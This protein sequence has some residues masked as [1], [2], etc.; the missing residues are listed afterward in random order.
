MVPEKEYQYCNAVINATRK[1][2][3][4]MY[5]FRKEKE[6]IEEMEDQLTYG[7]ELSTKEVVAIINKIFL[8]RLIGALLNDD[9]IGNDKALEIFEFTAEAFNNMKQMI[10]DCVRDEED[11]YDSIG[12]VTANRTQYEFLS[13][14][15]QGYERVVFDLIVCQIDYLLETFADI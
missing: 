9:E 6:M 10:K 5:S 4:P 11:K 13:R 15:F 1:Y 12:V 14:N 2:N 3:A 8:L 7:F